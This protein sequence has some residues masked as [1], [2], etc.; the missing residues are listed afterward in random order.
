VY[1]YCL[2]GAVMLWFFHALSKPQHQIIEYP[3]KFEYDDAQYIPIHSLP[4]T[5]K[6]RIKGSGWHVL[7]KQ[8]GLNTPPI[9]YVI[10]QPIHRAKPYIL[11]SILKDNLVKHLGDVTLDEI[12]TQRIPIVMDRKTTRLILLTL[13]PKH[14]A[15]APNHRIVSPILIQPERIAITGPQ[16]LVN[17]LK[18]PYLLQL[19]E[20]DAGNNIRDDFDKKI[21]IR[22][23]EDQG[24]FIQPE[25]SKV[26]INFKVAE[27]TTQKAKHIIDLVN[28]PKKS[29]F[30]LHADHRKTEITYTFR[31]EDIGKV[32]LSDFK[33]I[34]DFKSF[35][36][37]DSTISLTLRSKPQNVKLEDIHFKPKVKLDYDK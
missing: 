34:A 3:I 31:K 9:K 10:M 1:L 4:R 32:R 30:T 6:I 5:I 13:N 37:S 16:N 25:V 17:Q 28:F 36:S 18:N 19:G 7:L 11:T 33:I 22:F 29:R 26:K 14:I 8:L 27:F 12:I 21:K 15:L 2:L 24:Q 35:D 23:H 20:P